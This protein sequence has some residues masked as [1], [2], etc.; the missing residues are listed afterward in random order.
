MEYLD[1]LNNEKDYLN[2]YDR[3]RKR[4]DIADKYKAWDMDLV[5]EA[6]KDLKIG[7]NAKVID[8]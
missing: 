3:L 8:W 6:F 1:V 5:L 7:T 2:R 4:F